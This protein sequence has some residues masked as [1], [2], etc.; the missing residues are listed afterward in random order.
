MTLLLLAVVGTLP[1]VVVIAL[2]GSGGVSTS[3]ALSGTKPSAV[4]GSEKTLAPLRRALRDVVFSGMPKK[5]IKRLA[6]AE[7]RLIVKG[8]K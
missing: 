4:P 3:T 1:L 7:L 5:K 2:L 6:A 8:A